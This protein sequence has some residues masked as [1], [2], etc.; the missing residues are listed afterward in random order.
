MTERLKLNALAWK[1]AAKGI[2]YGHFIQSLSETEKNLIFEEYEQMLETRREEENARL[3]LARKSQAGKKFKKRDHQRL[4]DA[5]LS[6]H[7]VLS[8]D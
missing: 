2:S 3:E 1:A 4:R 6:K 7:S 5:A 8:G